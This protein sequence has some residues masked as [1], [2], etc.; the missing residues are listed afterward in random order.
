MKDD[1]A[2]KKVET[3][4]IEQF[5]YPKFGPGQLWEI[6]ADDVRAM[7]GEV[8]MNHE[9][10]R[11]NI[12]SGRVVSADCRQS[13]GTIVN[14]PCDYL[15]STMPIKDLVAAIS[16]VD[17]PEDVKRIAAELPYRD[18][19]T[20]GLLLDRMKI[21]NET[22]MKTYADRVPDTWIYIQERDVKVGRL[23]VFNN[24]SPYL[25][26]DYENTMFVG[27]EYFCNEGDEL[28][29]MDDEKFK[30]MA[31]DELVKID[32][33][34]RDAVLDATLVRIKKAYPAYFGSYYE[35][36]KVRR[37]LDGIENLYCL[38]RNGQHRYNNMDHSMMTAMVAVDNIVSGGGDKSAVWNV[39]TETEY[40]EQR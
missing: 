40:H 6:V 27:L 31:I 21:K 36:D 38:G 37:F 39:N 1:I 34:E 19:M 7:G 11:I 33:I 29:A 30:S 32:V 12:E 22:K 15:L 35:L 5:I 8:K 9:V 17:V 24:W 2:Q 28:W 25:V 18:F 14:M 3:S 10:V 23:Q 26:D 13:D 4:L 20:V 16:G